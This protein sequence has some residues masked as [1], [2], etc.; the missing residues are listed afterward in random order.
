MEFTQKLCPSQRSQWIQ[1]L[2]GYNFEPV[3]CAMD[4]YDQGP[5]YDYDDYQCKQEFINVQV[6]E[7]GFV[8]ETVKISSGC[9]AWIKDIDV[10]NKPVKQKLCSAT[11]MLFRPRT[12]F[13]SNS[14][15]E[16]S[17]C[18]ETGL[19]SAISSLGG[20]DHVCRQDYITLEFAGKRMSIPSGCS[21]Y[22]R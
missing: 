22:L 15:F 19:N 21:Y 4:S 2:H 9:S 5:L 18:D 11:T 14:I 20:H 10:N 6:L 3:I 16:Y 8:K 13:I 1:P 17:V 12:P 7:D